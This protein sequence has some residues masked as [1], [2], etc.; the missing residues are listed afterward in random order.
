MRSLSNGKEYSILKVLNSDV[1]K[2]KYITPIFIVIYT[3]TKRNYEMQYSGRQEWNTAFIS[4]KEIAGR[5]ST[6]SSRSG[7]G[8]TGL[9][10]GLKTPSSGQ[11]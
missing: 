1:M 5:L 8:E 3:N 10:C 4:E 11:L 9:G 6:S 7:G 2:V